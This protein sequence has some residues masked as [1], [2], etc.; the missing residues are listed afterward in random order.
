[1]LADLLRN[2]LSGSLRERLKSL[3]AQQ[4]ALIMLAGSACL[5]SILYILAF[6]HLFDLVALQHFARLDLQRVNMI[7]PR[8]HWLYLFVFIDLAILY[9]LAWRATGQVHERT[10]WAIVVAGALASGVALLLFY[11]LDATDIFDNIMHGRILGIYGANP[12]VQLISQFPHDPFAPYVGWPNTPSAYG[13]LWEML[14]GLTARLAGNGIVANVIAF[15]VLGGLFLAGSAA[16]VAAILRQVA[17][18]RALA[19]VLLL[20]WNPIVLY[21]TLGNGHNDIV[22]VFWMLA[23]AWALLNR[24]YTLALLTLL[25]GGLVKFIPVLLIPAAGLIALRDLPRWRPRLRFLAVTSLSGLAMIVL[26]YAPFWQGIKVL[27]ITRREHLFTTSLAAAAYTQLAPRWGADRAAT[28][29]SKVIL[30]LAIL[31]ALGMA[32]R[33]WRDRSWGS[34]ARTGVYTL[35]FYLLVTCPWFQTWYAIWPLGLAVLLAGEPAARLAQVLAFG[36]LAKPLVFGPMYLWIVPFPPAAWRELRLGP[37]VMMVP[38]LY[39]LYL[40][41]RS[42]SRIRIRERKSS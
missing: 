41:G 29:I 21:E 13:P 8:V 15:K 33:A 30:V 25:A 2:T 7:N 9:A 3:T 34:F 26:A 40:I 12:F 22:M 4:S 18:R 27:G 10:A 6:M 1:M 32:L 17:P 20:T 35:T 31:F 39:A 38:W 5:S 23:A 24:H 14:A 19:G 16:L 37:S 11:P 42:I 36:T 28:T